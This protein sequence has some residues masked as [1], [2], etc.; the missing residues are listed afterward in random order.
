VVVIIEVV[1]VIIEV[2]VVVV[3][4]VVL[5]S[6]VLKLSPVS[7]KIIIC[8]Y[9][10]TRAQASHLADKA[11]VHANVVGGGRVAGKNKHAQAEQV[12]PHVG[13]SDRKVHVKVGKEDVPVVHRLGQGGEG[14]EVA[15]SD[16]DEEN[17]RQRLALV[18][19]TLLLKP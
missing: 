7:V 11:G 8:M 9:R 16:A 5:G 12:Y 6:R 15:Y 13:G 10:Y 17:A 19:L 14:E 18:A 3:V 1:V 4:V 2:V